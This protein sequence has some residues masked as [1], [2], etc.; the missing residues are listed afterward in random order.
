VGSAWG[1]LAVSNLKSTAMQ[2]CIISISTPAAMRGRNVRSCW[3]HPARPVTLRNYLQEASACVQQRYAEAVINPPLVPDAD[4]LL[5]STSTKPG[6]A[7]AQAAAAN[8]CLLPCDHP[9]MKET[10]HQLV[11]LAS[12]R[13]QLHVM[14]H[15]FTIPAQRATLMPQ[16]QRSSLDLLLGGR[17]RRHICATKSKELE[18][19]LLL[20]P[21]ALQVHLCASGSD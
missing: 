18:L 19:P 13:E 4:S 17:P 3:G 11:A 2:K 1:L 6:G 8:C 21:P 12:K 7:F 20:S 14:D 15:L 16:T 10:L 9:N 5:D